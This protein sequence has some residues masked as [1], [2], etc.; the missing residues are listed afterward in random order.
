MNASLGAAELLSQSQ[1]E[2]SIRAQRDLAGREPKIWRRR[3]E[4]TNHEFPRSRF[5]FV[6]INDRRLWPGLLTRPRYRPKVSISRPNA[7][8]LFDLETSGRG[9]GKVRRPCHNRELLFV[10]QSRSLALVAILPER[11]VLQTLTHY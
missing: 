1:C 9:S 10:T 2:L 11:L 8:W 4:G 7:V 3:N 5:G 6:Q